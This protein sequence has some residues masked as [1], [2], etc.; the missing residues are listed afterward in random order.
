[1]RSDQLRPSVSHSHLALRGSVD[2][3]CT[4]HVHPQRCWP[5]VSSC[6]LSHL[7][8]LSA[9]RPSHDSVSSACAAAVAEVSVAALN[10]FLRLRRA[11]L[12]LLLSPAAGLGARFF[13]SLFWAASF[14][15]TI[16]ADQRS[17]AHGKGMAP[18]AGPRH[19]AAGLW[20]TP[21]CAARGTGQCRRRRHYRRR[22]RRPSRPTHRLR[23]CRRSE[24][25]PL[26]ALV[27][28]AALRPRSMV[29]LPIG[30]L[31]SLC[32][33][34]VVTCQRSKSKENRDLRCSK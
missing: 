13:G 10:F 22:R 4:S 34:V 16:A 25:A 23:P 30:L 1:M 3:N 5:C 17:Q 7:C 24:A 33:A 14:Y 18:E 29:G 27:T 26:A 28:Q 31:C 8:F 12:W 11:Y 15:C 9:S 2:D 19:G 21:E 20:V 32:G 6:L